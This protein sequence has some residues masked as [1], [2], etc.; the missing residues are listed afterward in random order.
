MTTL[1]PSDKGGASLTLS[2]GNLTASNSS[3]TGLSVRATNSA[4]A[5]LLYFEVTIVA[6]A[7]SPLII[8][9][10]ADS[11]FDVTS[12][13]SSSDL[14]IGYAEVG[15]GLLVASSSFSG[16][17]VAATTL[18][19]ADV[20][21]CAVDFDTVP[22]HPRFFFAKNNT[23]QN[24][25]NPVTGTGAL[26]VLN[27]SAFFPTVSVAGDGSP[28]TVTINFGTSAQVYSPPSG[29]SSWDALATETGYPRIIML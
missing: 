17:P 25:A 12:Y 15:V 2:N 6:K 23:W 24:G 7:S 29:Y 22:G 19:V 5:G 28:D 11:G 18:A 9:G 16:V 8:A 14:S 4:S 1:N 20:F 3:G 27:S 13:I 21:G 26:S 10:F